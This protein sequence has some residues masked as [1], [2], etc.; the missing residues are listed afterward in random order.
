MTFWL[1][2]LFKFLSIQTP[3]TNHPQFSRSTNQIIIIFAIFYVVCIITARMFAKCFIHNF[4]IVFNVLC[5][6]VSTKKY[7]QAKSSEWQQQW[8]QKSFPYLKFFIIKNNSYYDGC[9][10]CLQHVFTIC[11]QFQFLFRKK[12][13]FS[14]FYFSA[15]HQ[16]FDVVCT[17]LNNWN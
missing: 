15:I 9:R 10:W 12:R 3:P 4:S 5:R 14:T 17:F 2:N 11:W 13:Q 1:V 8:K 7:M 6:S 16:V